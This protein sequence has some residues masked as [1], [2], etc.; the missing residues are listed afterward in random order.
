MRKLPIKG[1]GWLALA[2]ALAVVTP[3][4]AAQAQAVVATGVGTPFELAFWQSIDSSNDPSLYESY[5]LR[6]PNG[7][8]NEIARAKILA[9]RARLG[10]PA[11][12]TTPAGSLPPAPPPVQPYV[13]PVQP[14]ASYPA[15]AAQP[16]PVQPTP[17]RPAI[18][19]P[20][21]VAAPPVAA[22]VVTPVVAAPVPAAPVAQPA[23]A[24]AP[25]PAAAAAQPAVAVATAA[26]P[27]PPAQI[28]PAAQPVPVVQPAVAA[29]P[30]AGTPA[31]ASTLGQL[32]A[33]L[34]NSQTA[35]SVAPAAI[36]PAVAVAQSPVAAVP[37]ATPAVVQ[38]AAVQ[39]ASV[40][41]AVAQPA[42]APAVALVAPATLP[43]A[44]RSTLAAGFALPPA[45]QLLPVPSVALPP[46]FCSAE[47]RNAFHDTVYAP[48]VGAAK[49]NNDNA[50][51]YMRQ[52]Q[53]TYDQYQL[54]H[55]PDTMNA[56]VATA[57]GYQ[58]TAQMTFAAQSSLVR[59][60]AALMAVPVVACNQPGQPGA[61]TI[62]K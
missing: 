18:V 13:P 55:D 7:T 51:A 11:P 58:P 22:P 27:V 35:G 21:P 54:S 8:F 1:A 45:P 39:P 44:G 50:A 14:V 59:Q 34:A 38:P 4:G 48:A 42:A 52:L 46:S 49:Q 53:A 9:L 26:V 43:G 25:A 32:L 62:A 10:S 40:Q 3:G 17:V 12:L 33:A 28:A 20:A 2:S 57:R 15:A 5:L 16:A 6:Y 23:V 37:A 31:A 19:S 29:T 61:T 24:V 56:I 30:P 47:A 36:Q 41:S 60:F